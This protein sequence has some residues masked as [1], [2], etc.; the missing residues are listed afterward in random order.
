[1]IRRDFL[2]LVAGSAAVGAVG[3][4]VAGC[5]GG[6]TSNGGAT[7]SGGE[8]TAPSLTYGLM[9][10]PMTFDPSSG[11]WG[12]RLPYYQL[13]YDTLL[14]AT[15]EG[16]IDPWLAT[17]WSYDD[18]ETA[19]TLTLRDDVTFS[20]GATLDAAA[21]QASMERF[22][23]GGG[24]DQGY[25]R[26]VDSV[27]APDA[28]TVVVHLT[29]PDPA[30]LNYLTRTAG[31]VLSPNAAE[32][33]DLDT[34]PVGSGPYTLDA[35]ASV[36]GTS[37]VFNRREGYWN[38]DAQ[39]YDTITLRVFNDP[40][41]TLNALRAGEL[42]AAKLQTAEMF[43]QAQQAGWTLNENELDFS[44]LLL[45]DRAGTMA[46]PLGDVR[47]RKAIN[48]AVDREAFLQAVVLGYGTLTEQVFPPTS[49]AYDEALDSTYGYDPEGARA[50]LAEAGYPNGFSLEMPSSALLGTTTFNLL[51]QALGDIG[52]TVTYVDPG[53]NF[54]A[55]L[56]APRFAASYMS[57]EQNPDWQLTQFMVS[58]DAV[59]NPFHY[60][61]DQV[62]AWL[63]EYL[64][65]DEARRD[66][67]MGELNAYL[68]DQAWFAPFFRIPGVVA[69]D[70]NTQVTMLPTNTL[71]NMYDIRPA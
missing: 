60:A 55:D 36:S 32:N 28:T 12:N 10:A 23:T 19:L 62:N 46:P 29:Q 57:L 68:V 63:E 33:A 70:P 44:G 49:A 27:E 14:C 17:E 3:A 41:A 43:G 11:E 30:F 21:V 5:G 39:H 52:I 24:P 67:I 47:V 37:Y 15:P 53:Q 16:G 26:Y 66:A 64:Q 1:M 65:A 9:S 35:G 59:F 61:D 48:M 42:N 71:P 6:Q 45:L 38:P 69:S 58:E 2:K 51:Q 22:R 34:N 4:S 25:M 56:L 31:L 13:P 18:T 8:G 54:I 50:L 20:D 40:T 7:G